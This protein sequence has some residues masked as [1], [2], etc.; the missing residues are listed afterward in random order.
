[1]RSAHKDC[2]NTH[3]PKIAACISFPVKNLRNKLKSRMA[4]NAV[5]KRKQP[6]RG[7]PPCLSARVRPIEKSTHIEAAYIHSRT[8]MMAINSGVDVTVLSPAALISAITTMRPSKLGTIEKATNGNSGS[9]MATCWFVPALWSVL[10]CRFDENVTRSAW[11]SRKRLSASWIGL[12]CFIHA[13]YFST[14][15]G[16]ADGR[17]LTSLKADKALSALVSGFYRT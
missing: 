11:R 9:H 14:S 5:S 10:A 1:V 12:R 8:V 3:Q 6:V 16:R 17:C 2:E 13:R 4:M 7:A 15:D